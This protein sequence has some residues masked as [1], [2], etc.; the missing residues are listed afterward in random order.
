MTV[1]PEIGYGK[2]PQHTQFKKGKSGNPRGR[3][4]KELT[5]FLDIAD[6]VGNKRVTT[7]ERGRRKQ[8]GLVEASLNKLFADALRGEPYAMRL[9]IDLFTKHAKLKK[10]M[11][12]LFMRG[13]MDRFLTR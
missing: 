10:G 6:Y 4:K 2:P 1:V 3:P 8:I 7:Y 12:D 13:L 11:N 9:V 5:T